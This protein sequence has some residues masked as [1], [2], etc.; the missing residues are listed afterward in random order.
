MKKNMITIALL[1]LST[2]LVG[3]GDLG[4]DFDFTHDSPEYVIVA[5]ESV[6][7]DS[8]TLDSDALSFSE[9][10]FAGGWTS[11]TFDA[12]VGEIDERITGLQVLNATVYGTAGTSEMEAD[13]SFVQR[14]EIYVL[15]DDGLPSFLLASYERDGDLRNPAILPL[16]IHED[17][18]LLGHMEGGLKFYT[19]LQG[20]H[21][22][23][24]VTFQTSLDFR[25]FSR[26]Y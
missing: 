23:R 10:E 12:G 24:N 7:A 20:E 22:E 1:A 15:G 19:F 14:M 2:T 9:L 13:L 16:M 21:P 26:G 25:G 6:K 8:G 4:F 11:F 17:V 18:N 5:E 3:C